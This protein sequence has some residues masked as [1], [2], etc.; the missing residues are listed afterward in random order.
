MI[1]CCALPLLTG[2]ATIMRSAVVVRA[3]L[4]LGCARPKVTEIKARTYAAAGCGIRATY[5]IEGD[6]RTAQ[7]CDAVLTTPSLIRR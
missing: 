6:C 2:C 7:T 3:P 5:V 4:D 1:A